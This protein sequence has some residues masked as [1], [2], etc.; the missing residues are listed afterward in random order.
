MELVENSRQ[1]VSFDIDRNVVEGPNYQVESKIWQTIQTDQANDT[2]ANS[3][4]AR[5]PLVEIDS[6]RRL[7]RAEKD[8]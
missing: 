3:A 1:K 7:T 5:C 6:T 4:L 8:I 2:L